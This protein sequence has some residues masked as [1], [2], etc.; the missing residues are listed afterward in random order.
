LGLLAG[1]PAARIA[2]APTEKSEPS[3]AGVTVAAGPTSLERQDCKPKDA[4]GNT[5]PHPWCEPL[6]V[7]REFFGIPSDLEEPREKNLD[8]VVEA[9]K[10]SG[11]HLHFMVTLVPAPLDP[12]LDEALEAMKRGFAQS[13]YLLDR[14]WL[15][16]TIADKTH[17]ISFQKTSGILLFRRWK[18]G[19]APELTLVFVVGETSKTGIQKDAFQEALALIGDLSRIASLKG[20]AHKEK[21]AILGPSF[22][23]SAESLRVALLHWKS[24]PEFKQLGFQ[25]VTGSATASHLEKYF[26]E[27]MNFCRMVLPDEVLH[28]RALKF[29]QDH[30]GWDLRRVALLTESDTAYGRSLLESEKA[31]HGHEHPPLVLI[32][33]PSQIS[34]LRNAVE[35]EEEAQKAA[36]AGS[37]IPANHQTLDLR[38]S[39]R[40]QVEDLVPTFSTLTTYSNELVLSNLLQTIAREGIRYVGIMATDVKDKIFL[41]EAVREFAPDVVLFTFDN[42]LLYAH[43]EYSVT[44]D[45][46]LVFSSS[47]LFTE[48]TPWLPGSRNKSR[49]FR[50]RQFS[51]EF[52][53]GVYDAVLYLLQGDR[54]VKPRGWITAVGNG[55]LWPIARLRGEKDDKGHHDTARLCGLASSGNPQQGGPQKKGKVAGTGFEGKD[56]LEIL[57]AAVILY[58]LAIGLNR[59]ALLGRIERSARTPLDLVAGNRRLLVL[60]AALLAAAAG[61]LLAVGSIPLW[62]HLFY[63]S[64]PWVAW[65]PAQLVYLLALALVYALLVHNTARAARGKRASLAAG[66]VW[67]LGGLLAFTLLVLGIWWFCVPGDQIQLFHLRARVLSSGLSPLVSLC[68]L[69]GAIY[70]WLWNE[71]TRRRLMARLATDC[72]LEALCDPAMSG[73][74]SIL[75]SFRELLTRSLPRGVRPWALPLIAFVPPVSLL[76]VTFQPIGET[77][78]YGRFF[79]LFLAVAFSLSALSFYRFVRL[80]QGTLRLLHRLD[81][82]SPEVAKAFEDISAELDW[83]PIKSFGWQLPP[84]RTLVLSVHKLRGLVDTGRVKVAGYPESLEK[85]LKAVFDNERDGGSVPEIENRNALEE[86][87]A[88]ACLDLRSQL[89]EPEVKQ[90]LALRVAAY[91]R[92]IFAHMRNCLTG[93]L[94]SGL[95]ALIGVTTYVFEPKHFVSLAGWL[96]LVVAVTLVLGIF[97]QMDR[98]PTLSRI[99]RTIPGQVTFDRAFLTKLLTY[100]GIPVLGLIATQFPQV[101]RMIGQV[102]GQILRI[103]GGG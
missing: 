62:A 22:S 91:L 41:A 46:M 2:T 1:Y 94:T 31:D 100:G 3:K 30:M 75:E 90:F 86:I 71:L 49:E 59:A 78:G 23:G 67:T 19:N 36:T 66:A 21:V 42:N 79:V 101:G 24:S 84:F 82:A 95:L 68:A 9:A 47:P 89:G 97:L 37:P 20:V 55:S 26:D 56:D 11:Y 29:L 50:R 44:M 72:P 70:V 38:L 98:N 45:G 65:E 18:D 32:P 12:R 93:A 15:P 61:V 25:I 83:R 102:A 33:F 40:E 51:S 34:D 76:W 10:K 6:R 63:P 52:Q 4:Q 85:P 103:G 73:S 74:T 96:A 81:N 57:L 35:T 69:G 58:L 27:D 43:P 17:E 53:Q 64:I 77:R 87:F 48:G 16:W 88:Q 54:V 7:L 8:D 39:G 99:G 80:W 28:E 14:I 13:N 5:S 92:Y 60:G